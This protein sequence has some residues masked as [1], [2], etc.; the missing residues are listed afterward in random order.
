[1]SAPARDLSALT[2]PE[3][4]ALDAEVRAAIRRVRLNDPTATGK[5]QGMTIYNKTDLCNDVAS[6]LG[7]PAAH[8][9]RV[10]NTTLNQ[11]EGRAEDGDGYRLKGFG[12]FAPKTRAARVARNPGTGAPVQVPARTVLT[13]K[14]A[15][16]KAGL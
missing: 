11:I 6:A 2:L 3:L 14:A 12:T 8:V 1:M 9:E 13:F 7:I 10:I 15:A 16:K 4:H 5:D